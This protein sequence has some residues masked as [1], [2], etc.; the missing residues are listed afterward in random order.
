MRYE[1]AVAIKTGI[2]VIRKASSHS[3]VII[4][5]SATNTKIPLKIAKPVK[6]IPQVSAM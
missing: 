5:K 2:F 3:F 4:L 1:M 6:I